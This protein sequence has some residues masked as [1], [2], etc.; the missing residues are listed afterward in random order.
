M[1]RIYHRYENWEDYKNG[2]Y[3]NFTEEKVKSAITMFSSEKLTRKYMLKVINEWKYSCEHNLTN[4]SLNRIAYIGQA[5]CCIYDSIPSNATKLAWGMLS[6]EIRCRSN[7]IA[8]EVLNT[9]IKRNNI[10]QLTIN[11]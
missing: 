8:K 4:I 9:W 3:D 10:V 1:E 7:S 6:D 5:A 11:I 2:F